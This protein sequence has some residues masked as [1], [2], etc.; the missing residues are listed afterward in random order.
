LPE[1][2]V[3]H[4][5]P[6]GMSR[7]RAEHVVG[8]AKGISM[9]EKD[10]L[11]RTESLFFT[12]NTPNSAKAFERVVAHDVQVGVKSTTYIHYGDAKEINSLDVGGI[13][14][15][16]TKKARELVTEELST[17]VVVIETVVPVRM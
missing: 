5:K 16:K 15:V 17:G 8:H 4:V 12:E 3:Q 6:K 11:F 7:L 9:T 2:F 1:H 14:V 10:R 13:V